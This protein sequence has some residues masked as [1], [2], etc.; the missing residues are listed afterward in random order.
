MLEEENAS[1]V[2][3]VRA[4]KEVGM[5]WVLPSESGLHCIRV[6][7]SSAMKEGKSMRDNSSLVFIV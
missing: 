3:S 2:E 7:S 4:I 6:I 1:V 5:K